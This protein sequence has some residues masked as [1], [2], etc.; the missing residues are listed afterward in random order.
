MELKWAYDL[1]IHTVASPCGDDL[2]TPNNIVNMSLL[3]GLDVIAITDHQTIRN[4]E[5]V[6]KVGKAK[7]LHV[8]AGMEI[9]CMEE[10]HLIALFKNLQVAQE[11]ER[12]LWQYLP[13]IKNKPS[14]FGHQYSLNEQDK[15]TSEIE[16]L[17]L[18]AAQVGVDT[19]LEKAR[20]LDT[21][22]YPAHIDRASYSILSNLGS[23]PKE[24]SFR[25]LEISKTASYKSY[26]QQYMQYKII[27]SSDAHYLEDIAERERMIEESVFREWIDL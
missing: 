17:L 5:S 15:V 27:Q 20:A 10:F 13:N 7:G 14:I 1:H 12:W 23:V 18:V 6:M 2:M 21:L 26:E 4:C 3:K 9:E 25:F 8:I 16:R 19:I 22:I 11:M 24:Y